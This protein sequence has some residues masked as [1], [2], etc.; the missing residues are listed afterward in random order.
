MRRKDSFSPQKTRFH[1]ISYQQTLSLKR[2]IRNFCIYYDIYIDN[3]HS[4][5]VRFQLL[6]A[7]N[8]G[9]QHEL[10]DCG[11]QQALLSITEISVF[12][13]MK[14]KLNFPTGEENSGVIFFFW[15]V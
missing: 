15:P 11:E 13:E 4:G 9:G 5:L 7:D 10:S 14:V 6:P 12:E 1:T 3:L 8:R 2:N